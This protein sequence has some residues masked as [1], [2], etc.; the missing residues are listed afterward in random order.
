MTVLT[1][2]V[3]ELET[4]GYLVFGD[5]K[6]ALLVDPGDEAE[7]ILQAVKDNGLTVGAIFLTHCHFDHIL[8]ARTVADATGAPVYIHELDAPALS[9]PRQN[10]SV[11]Y[12]SPFTLTAD[13]TLVDGDILTVGEI[14]AEVLHTPG[15]SVGC[16]CL[17]LP[18]ENI[19][20]SGDTLF[21][22]GIGRT[23]FPGGSYAQI[24]D[25]LRRLAAL[26]G[27]RA[28]Y[29]GHGPAT[30]LSAER[31]RNPLMA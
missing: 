21:A 9:D 20:L 5:D 29:P 26:E 19:L 15:H 4:N 24:K 11:F 28:V 22:N 14:K 8:A 6:T 16:C 25:S 12:R 23:D 30:T 17:D 7:K 27:D 31:I 2:P 10:L 18:N 13:N 1:I 3:G